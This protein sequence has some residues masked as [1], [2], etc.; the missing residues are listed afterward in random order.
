MEPEFSLPLSSAL[1][2]S[3]SSSSSESKISVITNDLLDDIE[4]AIK[5]NDR[6]KLKNC[7]ES[8]K[9]CGHCYC[10]TA[11]GVPF[12]IHAVTQHNFAVYLMLKEI[13]CSIGD[14]YMNTQNHCNALMYCISISPFWLIKEYI[15][16]MDNETASSIINW[17]NQYGVTSL[18]WVNI[19]NHEY[20]SEITALL[21]SKGGDATIKD[22]KGLTF[23][24]YPIP[25]EEFQSSKSRRQEDYCDEKKE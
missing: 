15:S 22:S 18:H 6:V 13:G 12:V 17:Q 16:D 4:I 8:M 25:V 9:R 24:N 5:E 19:I 7:I 14:V 20:R 11:S 23:D 1:S 2:S 3:S 21:L 10:R